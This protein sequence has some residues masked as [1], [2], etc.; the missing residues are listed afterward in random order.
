[1]GVFFFLFDFFTD[2]AL[3]PPDYV[4]RGGHRKAIGRRVRQQEIAADEYT[5]V[6]SAAACRRVRR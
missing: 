3:P 6:F 1:L 5:T 4:G 2:A